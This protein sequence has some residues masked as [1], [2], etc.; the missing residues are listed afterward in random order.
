V[1]GILNSGSTTG[2]AATSVVSGTTYTGS[3]FLKKIAGGVDWV[4]V[5]MGAGGFGS[6]QYANFNLSTGQVGNF[7][8][9]ASGTSPRIEAF[10]NGWYRCSISVTATTT[11]T[12]SFSVAVYST[13]NTNATTRAPSYNGN[14]ANKFL[15][16]MAQF[17]AGSFP[18]SYIPT[19][20][21]SVVRSADVCSISGGNFTSFYNQPEG[22]LFADVTPQVVAQ[23]S[24]ILAVNISTFQSA[25]LIY[26]IDSTFNT[27]GRRWGGQTTVVN[28]AQTA[29]VTSTDVAVSRS[30]LAYAY[31]LN[32][33]A[34]AASGSLVGTDTSGT[35][36]SPTA[37]R[38]GSRDDGL[39]IN[40]HLAE[41]RYY[42]KRLSNAK[43]QALTA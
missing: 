40:G 42:K 8:G 2:T 11:T 12:T 36:P 43:L 34:F 24:V 28:T 30:R 13:N 16:A 31:K 41:V 33:F 25:H 23:A 10:A 18:T 21:G 17:E 6:A 9:L 20:T 38:I 15:A 5:T 14:T 4:Q 26:K 27:A 32:D 35:V 37:M 22:T 19:T 39:S 3:V 7:A 29:I 1:H